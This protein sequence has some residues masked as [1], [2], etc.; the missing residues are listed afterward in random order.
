MEMTKSCFIITPIGGENTSIRRHADGV[1]E[2]VISPML[3]EMGY[4]TVVAHK[5][6]KGG[7][8]TR[9]VIE[10]V[11]E[12]DLVI[13]NLSGL[14]PNVMY[15]LAVRHAVRK[16][17]VQICEV[18][19]QLPFDISQ[20]RT[21][22]Y[23]NDM[24]GSVELKETLFEMIQDAISEEK[25]DNPIYNSIE[26]STIM[27]STETSTTEK[28]ILERFSELE[29]NVMKALSYN[30]K[31]DYFVEFTIDKKDEYFLTKIVDDLSKK[32][33]FTLEDVNKELIKNNINIP[34]N[35]VRETVNNTLNRRA[36]Q[37]SYI[38]ALEEFKNKEVSN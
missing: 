36:N 27:K 9:Q 33:S 3:N 29:N 25:P 35:I 23:T 38:T 18:G 15:E 4:E 24:K 7:S 1:I 11:I 22:F 10:N 5:I 6:S 14:N 31:R 20:L 32:G 19:T 21:I 37:H 13:A 28:Y 2:A 17:L 26:T 30:K 16:P 8:I 12:S 34:R